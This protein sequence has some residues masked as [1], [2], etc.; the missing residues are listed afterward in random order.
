[1]RKGHGLDMGLRIPPSWWMLWANLWHWSHFLENSIACLYMLGHQYPYVRAR[2]AND[3]PPVWLPHFPLCNS[4]RSTSTSS[5]CTQQI[6]SWIRP[7]IEFPIF[8]YPIDL[9]LIQ[10]DS[11]L[12]LSKLSFQIY[13]TI[14]SIQLADGCM[15]N[16]TTLLEEVKLEKGRSSI[17]TILRS[18]SATVE[19]R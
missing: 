5:G 1:M 2:C 18:G 16:S 8:G 13:A 4:S 15:L 9:H 12:S 6:G 14:G 17:D 19:A 10:L 7:L 11:F 3:L